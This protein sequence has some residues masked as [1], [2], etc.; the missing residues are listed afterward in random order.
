M[1]TKGIILVCLLFLLAAVQT[2]VA[3]TQKG[4]DTVTFFVE[5]M[6][7]EHC[8]SKVEK[9]IAF[10]KGVTDLKCD[11]EEKTVKITYK[12]EKTSPEKLIKGF[13]KI[14]LTA[15]PVD[16]IPDKEKTVLLQE[17]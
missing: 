3:Q 7:C 9:N 1:K 5:D 10:E 12:R 11:L 14:K 16:S 17:T 4:K 2:I 15:V 8:K 13:E 6:N